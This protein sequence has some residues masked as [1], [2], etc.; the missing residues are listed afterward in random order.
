MQLPNAVTNAPEHMESSGNQKSS[1]LSGLKSCVTDEQ[2]SDPT[3]QWSDGV[4]DEYWISSSLEQT[5][6]K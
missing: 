2:S 3:L 6:V 4:V 1:F 5:T